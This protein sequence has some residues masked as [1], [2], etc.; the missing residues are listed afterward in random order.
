MSL[1]IPKPTR[2]VLYLL[3]ANVTMFV[4]EGFGAKGRLVAVFALLP[5]SEPSG[6]VQI[7]RLVTYQFLHGDPGHIFW[8]ML[9][10]YF[11]GPPI[12]RYWGPKRFLIFYLSCGV[13]GGLVY[14]AL[15]A[16]TLSPLIGA[17]GAVLGLIPACAVL[18]PH[19]IIFLLVFPVPIRFAAS[20]IA[21]LSALYILWDRN[22]SE[23]C[24]LG[25]MAAGF[26]FTVSRPF[27][28]RLGA[29]RRQTRRQALLDEETADQ[30][31]VDEILD[32]VH[33]QGIQSLTWNEKRTLR[34][35]TRRQK[36]RDELKK[37]KW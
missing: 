8:N 2:M 19:M 36:K 18:F 30:K 7:W 21:I 12:E 29:E 26:L 1:G 5:S 35:I 25:G 32:K 15:S 13:I 27:W 11:F 28:Q 20:L 17:S 34:S 31:R 4:L 14:W 24:H 37:R 33:R 9:G 23:A 16:N 22:L 10:L 6:M 3:V